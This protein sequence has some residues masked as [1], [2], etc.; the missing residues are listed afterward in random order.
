[1]IAIPTGPR[2]GSS[3]KV[4]TLPHWVK[5]ARMPANSAEP[6]IA[7]NGGTLRIVNTTSRTIGSRFRT[8]MLNSL[9][10]IA[11]ASSV[12]TT[13][14]AVASRP[15]TRKITRLIASAGPA[16]QT[17]FRTW[18]PTVSPRP[19][20][21]GTRIVVS[22]SGVILSP[23]Y[24]PQITAPA[25]AFGESP[26]TRAIPTKATPIVPA[27]VQELPVTRPTTAQITAVARKKTFGL[28]RRIP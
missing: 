15:R 8:V 23:K 7:R 4:F 27:V 16:V 6:R 5:Q 25:A 24:A 2:L 28:R 10:R 13:A 14:F 17:M 11:R 20:S 19:T 1:L 22:E 12:E 21:F 9:P 3:T 18:R 26:I